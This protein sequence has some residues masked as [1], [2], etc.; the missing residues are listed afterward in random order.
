M[1]GNRTDYAQIKYTRITFENHSLVQNEIR[2]K[3]HS[4]GIFG[5]AQFIRSVNFEQH[6]R[7]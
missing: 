6:Y 5:S 1:I 4:Y 2:R 7:L 3:I